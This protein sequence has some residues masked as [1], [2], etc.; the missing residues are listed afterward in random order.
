M[1]RPSQNL[2]RKLIAAARAMLPKTGISGLSVR[3]VARRA[4]VNVGMFHYHFKTKESFLRRVTE[5]LYED[6]FKTFIEAAERRGDPRL[7][8]RRVLVAFARFA[9]ENRILYSLIVRELLNSSPEMLR[10]ARQ[11]YPRHAAVLMELL[12]ECRRERVV[13][14]VP[15]PL[16]AMFAM[17]T[18]GLPNV[19][20]TAFEA[21]GM[22]GIAGMPFKEFAA[23]ALSDEMIETRA[24]MVLAA[25]A[26]ARKR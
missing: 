15:V 14:P 3:E 21:N 24:D 13:R 26:P 5:E 22:R 11:N 17:S 16:L 12:E 23:M 10:F 7:R 2:D 18:M 6:F 8:L 9:R 4:G 25:L 19:A 20:I 1:S